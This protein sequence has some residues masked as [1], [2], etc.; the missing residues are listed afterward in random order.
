M[1]SQRWKA[2]P[3]STGPFWPGQEK[4]VWQLRIRCGGTAKTKASTSERGNRSGVSVAWCGG[5]SLGAAV[6]NGVH[7]CFSP[8]TQSLSS[9]AQCQMDACPRPS[10][11]SGLRT[12][13][14]FSL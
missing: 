1:L 8:R 5:G 6:A 4:G 12:I 13:F 2:K 10:L 3:D 7:V 14:R 9:F 11:P